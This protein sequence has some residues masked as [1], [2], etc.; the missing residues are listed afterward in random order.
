MVAHGEDKDAEIHQ[1]QLA[2]FYFLWF[3]RPRVDVPWH[4]RIRSTELAGVDGICHRDFVTRAVDEEHNSDS[5]FYAVGCDGYACIQ[6]HYALAGSRGVQ[7][8]RSCFCGSTVRCSRRSSAYKYAQ[9]RFQVSPGQTKEA[10]LGF[11]KAHSASCSGVRVLEQYAGYRD[12]D[13]HRQDLVETSRFLCVEAVDASERRCPAGWHCDAVGNFDQPCR[14]GSRRPS[15]TRVQWRTGGVEHFR[16]HSGRIAH[17]CYR[18]GVHLPD[19]EPPYQG[20]DG[21]RHGCHEQS[22][23]IYCGFKG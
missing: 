4:F 3:L 18:T 22:Q 2:P 21:V 16:N 13:S 17:T 11:N 20:Q 10:D 1:R 5:G 19:V 12:D 7:Q 23:R 6:N 9:T 14:E 8:R 15:S